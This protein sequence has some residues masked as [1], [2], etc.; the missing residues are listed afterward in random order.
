MSRGT[1][2][3]AAHPLT[4]DPPLDYLHLRPMF[5]LNLPPRGAKSRRDDLNRQLHASMQALV[6]PTVAL[7]QT[8]PLDPARASVIR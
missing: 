7:I 6:R 3:S 8:S 5:N 2:V 4:D 1:P